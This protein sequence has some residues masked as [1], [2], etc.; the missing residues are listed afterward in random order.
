MNNKTT[1]NDVWYYAHEGT[2][3]GPFT[4]AELLQK[5]AEGIVK[6]ETLVVPQGDENWRP[7]SATRIQEGGKPTIQSVVAPA[8]QA[9]E[10]SQAAKNEKALGCGCALIIG[11]VFSIWVNFCSVP[12]GATSPPTVSNR[13]TQRPFTPED[14]KY[15]IAAARKLQSEAK[16][17][18]ADERGQ[19]PA[20]VTLNPVKNWKFKAKTNH[21][22]IFSLYNFDSR[23]RSEG[24][25]RQLVVEALEEMSQAMLYFEELVAAPADEGKMKARGLMQSEMDACEDSLAKA[26]QAVQSGSL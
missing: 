8:I 16:V 18:M 11:I 14:A 15:I 3:F 25:V 13:D 7:F 6:S 10:K 17:L 26:E 24:T 2:T 22:E 9:D 21:D 20:G 23:L 5:A 12:N 19:Q 1:P 4:H